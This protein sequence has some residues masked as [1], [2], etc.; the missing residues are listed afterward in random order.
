[1]WER[2]SQRERSLLVVLGVVVGLYLFWTFLLE[3]QL[4]TFREVR[5][6][7][8]I[9]TARLEK[10]RQLTG[11]LSREKEALRTAEER[12]ATIAPRFAIDLGDGTVLADI[13]LAAARQGV[14]VTLV[15]PGAVETKDHYLELPIEFGVE[16]D[17]PRVLE[18]L[19]KME[20]LA[21]FSE[22]R[23]LELKALVLAKNPGASPAT[24]DGRV[25]ASFTVVLY[26]AP[27]AENKL[28]LDELA[29]WALGRA[30]PYQAAGTRPPYPGI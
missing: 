7:L 29:A 18:F 20:N 3:W 23:Q 27:T 25:S 21:S 10:G 9:A 22:I 5:Y 30:N 26:A 24:A 2:L 4:E 12:L 17:Y 19:R 1:M 13:G 6:Q 16:G 8:K 28:R 11:S 15:R 14:T